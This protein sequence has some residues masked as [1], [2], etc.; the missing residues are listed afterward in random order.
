[1][2]VRNL[3]ELGKGRKTKV[4][5]IGFTTWAMGDWFFFIGWSEV[6]LLL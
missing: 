5:S 1:M 6:I 2:K 4:E 3:K